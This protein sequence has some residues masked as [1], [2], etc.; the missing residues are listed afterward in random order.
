M[1]EWIA[2]LFWID[3]IAALI[4]ELERGFSWWGSTRKLILLEPKQEVR[5]R[6]LIKP[7]KSIERIREAMFLELSAEV[8]VW[9]WNKPSKNGDIVASFD[10][11]RCLNCVAYEICLQP[12]ILGRR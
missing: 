3:S 6:D 8:K 1:K 9:D 7:S 12:L 5:L 4:T 10:K 2:G 11:N